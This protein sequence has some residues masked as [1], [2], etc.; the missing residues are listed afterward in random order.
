MITKTTNSKYVEFEGLRGIPMTIKLK[1]ILRGV[2]PYSSATWS[3]RGRES[4]PG[5]SLSHRTTVLF[6][7]R[8]SHSAASCLFQPSGPLTW[9]WSPIL[10]CP[11]HSFVGRRRLDSC[12]R[13]VRSWARPGTSRGTRRR[14]RGWRSSG[15]S[16]CG[17][18]RAGGLSGFE[19][20]KWY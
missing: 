2:G 18:D 3:C 7:R 8:L 5:P 17:G 4:Q 19:I 14:G 9:R 13:W 11:G 15:T 1:C 6:Y 12:P 20:S 16:T 10:T